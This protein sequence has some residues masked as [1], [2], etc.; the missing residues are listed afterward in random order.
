MKEYLNNLTEINSF[1]NSLCVTLKKLGYV[2]KIYFFKTLEKLNDDFIFLTFQISNDI[3]KKQ[4]V[5]LGISGTMFRI[6]LK[7]NNFL[8]M[9]NYKYTSDEEFEQGVSKLMQYS[10][11]I[12]AVND[13]CIIKRNIE[14]L[15]KKATIAADEISANTQYIT[16][17]EAQKNDLIK[18][19]CDD[20]TPSEKSTTAMYK[21]FGIDTKIA[22]YVLRNNELSTLVSECLKSVAELE[23]EAQ[24]IKSTVI[25]TQILTDAIF[26]GYKLADIKYE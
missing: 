6:K 12:E 14:V 13:F 15:K 10:S 9:Y 1:I 24:N 8:E 3:T 4:M 16:F 21:I 23:L 5:S 19:G 7:I 22:N 20:S 11:D 2:N 17:Y 25:N 26:F 18:S